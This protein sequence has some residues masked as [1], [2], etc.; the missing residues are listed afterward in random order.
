[1]KLRLP[2][3]RLLWVLIALFVL[4]LIVA[5]LI[6]SWSATREW[7]RVK[8]AIEAEGET[9][10][11][12]KLLPPPP[13]DAENF[14]AI[15]ALKD[16]ALVVD[17]DENKGEPA[18]RRKA[19]DPLYT[20]SSGKGAK[21]PA[22]NGPR[23][24]VA[25]D[26]NAWTEF[27]K[28]KE[29]FSF[30]EPFDNRGADLIE[31]IDRKMP[32]LRE[33]L[34]ETHRSRAQFT[35]A[36]G[37]RDW[38]ALLLLAP[39]V[40]HTPAQNVA[41]AARLRAVAA[42]HAGRSDDSFRAMLVMLR[43]SE[44]CSQEPFVIP[45]IVGAT[46]TTQLHGVVWEAL[47]LRALAEPELSRLQ[48]ELMRHDCRRRLLHA[49]RTDMAGGV[50]LLA[51]FRDR[52]AGE[53]LAMIGA[54]PHGAS[55]YVVRLAP[56]GWIDLNA[57]NLVNVTMDH[58]IRPLRDTGL[59]AAMHGEKEMTSLQMRAN[60]GPMRA[61]LSGFTALSISNAGTVVRMNATAQSINDQALTAI[62][63]ERYF[64]RHQKYPSALRDLAPEF[65]SSPPL[66]GLT[67]K[68]LGYRQTDDGRYMIW[69]FGFD[70][71]DDHG[72]VNA[73][74]KG[75]FS[76]LKWIDYKGDWTWQYRPIKP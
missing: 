4:L 11:L 24:G 5:P 17:G 42:V 63:M 53:A 26:L 76:S 52:D 74:G 32:V 2:G 14:C 31:A 73:F 9:F 48:D 30:P 67:G 28:S 43:L 22:S 19:L 41:N 1:M 21:S 23:E 59:L 8:A 57:L 51:Y 15:P 20:T 46:I 34:A 29:G 70:G 36:L 7:H 13:P 3:S 47:R 40:F 54:H 25:L 44:A 16:I 56:D 69:S 39:T 45:H 49:L 10:D 38:P 55:R 65:L 33:M 68:P 50:N 64:I 72:K 62:A 27:L 60:V 37:E 6:W 58:T 66:D 12:R 18:N 61:A 35:P 71:V 75:G